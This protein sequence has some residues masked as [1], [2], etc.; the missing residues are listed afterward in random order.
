MDDDKRRS[1]LVMEAKAAYAVLQQPASRRGGRTGRD[2]SPPA[3]ETTLADI[4]EEVTA[5]AIERRRRE[6]KLR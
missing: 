3:L 5:D 1:D 2:V 4:S 6:G